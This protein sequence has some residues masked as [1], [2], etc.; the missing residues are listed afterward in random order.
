MDAKKLPVT[1][2]VPEGLKPLFSN[3][4][5]YI[6]GELAY[7]YILRCSKQSGYLSLPVMLELCFSDPLANDSS[8]RQRVSYD[9]NRKNFNDIFRMDNGDNWI[10]STTLEPLASI[11]HSDWIT[12]CRL[13]GYTFSYGDTVRKYTP[14]KGFI[15]SLK[16]CPECMKHDLENGIFHYRLSHQVPGVTACHEHG[17]G[18]L[19][20]TGSIGKEFTDDSFTPVERYE[21]DVTVALFA[22]HL[23]ENKVQG[24][25]DMTLSAVSDALRN[26]Y[27]TENFRDALTVF[28][29]D[30]TFSDILRLCTNVEKM[31][32]SDTLNKIPYE[33][34]LR[35]LCRLYDGD[36]T[37]LLP[38]YTKNGDEYKSCFFDAIKD[39]FEMIS[40]YS[41]TAV[42]LRCLNCGFEFY[43][44]PHSILTGWGCPDEDQQLTDD[45]LFKKLVSPSVKKGWKITSDFRNWSDYIKLTDGKNVRKIRAYRL[46]EDSFEFNGNTPLTMENLRKEME[47]YPEF[48][49]I[50]TSGT[51]AERTLTLRHIECG[52]IFNVNRNNF[53]KSPFCRIC[54]AKTPQEHSAIRMER[55]H[56]VSNGLFTLKKEHHSDYMAYSEKLNKTIKATTFSDL[57]AKVQRA[58]ETSIGSRYLDMVKIGIERYANNHRGEIFTI[59]EFYRFGAKRDVS[60]TVRKL[61][62]KGIIRRLGKCIYCNADDFF[63]KDEIVRHLFRNQ[64]PLCDSLFTSL[65]AEIINPNHVYAKTGNLGKGHMERRNFNGTEIMLDVPPVPLIKENAAVIS[66]L[67]TIN[68]WDKVSSFDVNCK[69][70]L[71]KWIKE[72]EIRYEDVISFRKFFRDSVLQKAL[73]FINGGMF[74]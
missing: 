20:Y 10:E 13:R 28:R 34:M 7:S 72:N 26:R 61:V 36:I 60:Y 57:E 53:L 49:L 29:C 25:L 65:G 62:D 54:E 43:T 32:L 52:N 33:F 55:I 14:P 68:R 59:E 22:H 50:S 4:P 45:E 8:G 30:S 35:L 15:K 1:E 70:I 16:I 9:I 64:T 48:E 74:T 5:S 19:E 18:L 23:I 37:G 66:L 2:K 46:L 41:R 11:F 69:A 56:S 17:C 51:K 63:T 58:Y 6:K 21:D 40:P 38:F 47:K 12:G 3:L 24:N 31:L 42:T 44:S 71:Y 73:E 67:M 39:R 27:R